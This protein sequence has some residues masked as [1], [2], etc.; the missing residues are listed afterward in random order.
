MNPVSLKIICWPLNVWQFTAHCKF[1]WLNYVHTNTVMR[2]ITMTGG[3]G[4]Y[5]NGCQDAGW[6]LVW[7]QA[8][9][10][11]ILKNHKIDS[12]KSQNCF[13]WGEIT[14]GYGVLFC[15]N[16]DRSFCTL[17]RVLIGE[18]WG[19]LSCLVWFGLL[20]I[21]GYQSRLP[22]ILVTRLPWDLSIHHFFFDT[23]ITFLK[24]CWCNWNLS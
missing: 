14:N 8:F 22:L 24:S 4:C 17:F 16:V 21:Q 6:L 13:G 7:C 2:R 12:F 5:L 19:I 1:T 9:F 10:S 3:W 15:F 20:C 11:N 23:I 18:M